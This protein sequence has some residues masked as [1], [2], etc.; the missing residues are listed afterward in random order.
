MDDVEEVNDDDTQAVELSI[1]ILVD[2]EENSCNGDSASQSQNSNRG[3]AIEDSDYERPTTPCCNQGDRPTT[4]CAH[5][6]R[7][8]TPCCPHADKPT[9]PC[10]RTASASSLPG[11]NIR[12][13]PIC[14]DK[15]ERRSKSVGR[16]CSNDHSECCGNRNEPM[17]IPTALSCCPCASMRN[18]PSR[19]CCQAAA[20]CEATPKP[21][22]KCGTQ[23]EPTPKPCSKCGTPC[24]P[25]PKPCSKCGTPCEASPKPCNKCGTRCQTAPRP[26]SRSEAVC[27]TVQCKKS[28]AGCQSAPS[29]SYKSEAV[30]QTAPSEPPPPTKVKSQIST[31]ACQTKQCATAQTGTRP[32]APPPC[33]PATKPCAVPCSRPC[34]RPKT[35]KSATCQ[36]QTPPSRPTC[37][38]KTCQPKQQVEEM[39]P[40]PRKEKVK[41]E[42]VETK[43]RKKPQER[44][45]KQTP[46]RPKEE[47]EE[48]EEVV[49]QPRKKP[50]ERQRKQTPERPKEEEE[51]EEE[52]EKQPPKKPQE[53]QRKQTPER[54]KEEEEVEEEEKEETKEERPRRKSDERHRKKSDERKRRKSEER[55]RRKSEERSKRKSDERSKRKSEERRRSAETANTHEKAARRSMTEPDQYDWARFPTVQLSFIDYVLKTEGIFQRIIPANT[56]QTMTSQKYEKLCKEMLSK[57]SETQRSQAKEFFLQTTREAIQVK[58]PSSNNT[59]ITHY[60]LMKYLK[61]ITEALQLDAQQEMHAIHKYHNYLISVVNYMEERQRSKQIINP[62]A[63]VDI[64]THLLA[65]IMKRFLPLFLKLK[66]SLVRLSSDRESHNRFPPEMF[67]KELRKLMLAMYLE[68]VCLDVSFNNT[69]TSLSYLPSVEVQEKYRNHLQVRKTHARHCVAWG[70]GRISIVLLYYYVS[71]FV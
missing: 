34:C 32:C 43:P 39:K 69:L 61:P 2:N 44:Q 38:P 68:I 40:E 22:S 10:K 67:V 57:V 20:T 60:N 50:Q 21:C 7:P 11:R 36:T 63:L 19:P 64:E 29:K 18:A 65:G 12:I 8:A 3:K 24:E 48:E 6:E 31:V 14:V 35:A 62:D 58:V 15:R 56:K 37:R 54:P 33:R 52:V 59:T 46:E 49:K 42:E 53:R 70:A 55:Q 41:A 27:Q 16:Q 66:E 47:E 28:E 5:G 71:Q 23:C 4:P 45:R 30:C 13:G 26:C 1:V 25:T 51:E 9:T 17:I